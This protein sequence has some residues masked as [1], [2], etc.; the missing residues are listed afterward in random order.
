MTHKV[1]FDIVE[2][3]CKSWEFPAFGLIFII[4]GFLLVVFRKWIPGWWGNHPRARNTFS[5]FFIGFAVIWTLTSFLGTYSEY[6][7]LCSA[8]KNG[9][10]DVVE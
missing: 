9:N 5:L 7:N 10:F 2:A 6:S 8:Q 4:I 3:G 1:V